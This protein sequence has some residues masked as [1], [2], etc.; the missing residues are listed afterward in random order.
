MRQSVKPE[1]DVV[2]IGGGHAHALLLQAWGMKPHPDA[3]LTLIDPHP[4]APY[5]GMLPGHIAGHYTLTELE[6]DLVRLAR[7]AG[8]RLVSVPAIGIDREARKVMVEGRADIGYDLVS[9]NVGSVSSLAALPGFRELSN[10]AKPLGAFADAWDMFVAEVASGRSSPEAAVVGG[11]VAGVELA[12]AMDWRFRSAS[13]E[14]RRITLIEARSELLPE[15]GGGTRRRLTR[16]LRERGIALQLSESVSEFHSDGVLLASGKKIGCGFAAVAAGAA[17]PGWLRETGLKLHDGF[18]SVDRFLRSVSDESIHAAGDCAH[19]V[20]G[21]LPKAGVFAVRQAPVLLHNLRASLSEGTRKPFR[22]QTDF[23]RLVST[24]DASSVGQKFGFG[25]E[26]PWIWRFKDRIDRRFMRKLTDL[27]TMDA[28]AGGS[29]PAGGTESARPEKHALCGGCGSKL[30]RRP[31]L[32]ALRRLPEPSRS[33]VL[34]GGGDDAAALKFDQ[35]VQVI[36]TDHLRPLTGDSWLHARIAALHALGDVWAM[37]AKPQSAL[38]HVVLPEMPDLMLEST[39]EEIMDAAASAFAAEGAD[40]IGGHTSLGPEMLIGF[41]VTG[42][43]GERT[44]R[45][46]GARPGDR[47]IAT[48]A[49]GS[50]TILASEMRGLADGRNVVGTL[51]QMARSS[52]SAAEILSS[53]AN[54]MTDVSGFGLAGHLMEMLEQSG[55]SARLDLDSVPV[56]AGAEELAAK[57]VRSVIWPAN[58]E[59]AK[60]MSLPAGP[61]ADLLFDPQTAGGLLATVPESCAAEVLERLRNA[62]EPAAEIGEIATGEPFIRVE[63]SE[64]SAEPDSGR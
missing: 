25:A 9:I 12:L 18:V 43:A 51:N 44:I 46:G 52:G 55:I 64:M 13:P 7:H 32:G 27:P 28:N 36:S 11:G 33:D 34:F 54:A 29:R 4:K 56:L 47:I 49:I 17:A 8:A 20:D 10:P 61:R 35:Q 2:L 14:P 26:G 22:P 57:G 63:R 19:F 24:G 23:L 60:R 21:P 3:R 42:I 30:G 5:T 37:G 50:G 62:G 48:R 39:L 53:A 15:L 45:K 40:I 38:A 58:R 31:L 6:I 16:I 41:T 1:R 59:T